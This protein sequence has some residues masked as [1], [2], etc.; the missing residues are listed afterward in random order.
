MYTSWQVSARAQVATAT[1]S[2]AFLLFGSA[3]H[4]SEASRC[5]K[6][7]HT[8]PHAQPP[9]DTHALALTSL[10]CMS[11][12]TIPVW[13]VCHVSAA[14]TG[15]SGSSPGGRLSSSANINYYCHLQHRC[16]NCA[17]A[18]MTLQNVLNKKWPKLLTV[19]CNFLQHLCWY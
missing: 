8:G 11:C 13:C 16:C 17:S 9:P 14:L 18:A 3:E 7:T 6:C 5:V 4:R 12:V 2:A 19:S 1:G 10:C 15:A